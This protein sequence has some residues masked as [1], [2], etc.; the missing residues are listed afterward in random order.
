MAAKKSTPPETKK[1]EK[2]N[3]DSVKDLVEK[4][5]QDNQEWLK[6]MAKR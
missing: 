3:F 4:V 2:P 5:V 6:E 1:L